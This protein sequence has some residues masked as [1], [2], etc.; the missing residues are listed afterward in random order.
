MDPGQALLLLQIT[1]A[2]CMA[3]VVWIS[4]LLGYPCEKEGSA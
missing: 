2:I 4:H 1:A 3:G